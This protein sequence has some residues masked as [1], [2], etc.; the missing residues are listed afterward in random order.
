MVVGNP[1]TERVSVCSAGLTRAESCRNLS[2]KCSKEL[3]VQFY[4]GDYLEVL[5]QSVGCGLS[6]GWSIGTQCALR[7]SLP[8]DLTTLAPSVA[9]LSHS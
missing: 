1:V 9:R 3:P 7:P 8:A 2:P 6:V 4:S 5:A